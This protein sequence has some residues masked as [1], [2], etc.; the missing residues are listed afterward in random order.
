MARMSKSAMALVEHGAGL[1]MSV[2]PVVT[3]SWALDMAAYLVKMYGI[4]L[5]KAQTDDWWIGFGE[6]RWKQKTG[7]YPS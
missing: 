4:T 6:I 5:T 2:D 1:M 7:Q 3:K